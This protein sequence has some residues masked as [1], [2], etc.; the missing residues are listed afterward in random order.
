MKYI[1]IKIIFFLIFSLLFVV[2]PVYAGQYLPSHREIQKGIYAVYDNIDTD[3][4][5][6]DIF[7][8]N[9][10]TIE[11]VAF[12]LELDDSSIEYIS[13][14]WNFLNKKDEYINIEKTYTDRLSFAISS[15]GNSSLEFQ[16][17]TPILS[18]KFKDQFSGGSDI[19]ISNIYILKEGR[20]KILT[21]QDIE[22]VGGKIISPNY[23]PQA[24]LSKLAR[25]SPIQVFL[26]GFL[27]ILFLTVGIIYKKRATHF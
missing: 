1:P 5:K 18:L 24:G 15:K 10:G 11:G 27:T 12:D 9:L 16:E 2:E 13:S 14:K 25:Y 20:K 6:I 23:L 21:G 19:S 17:N 8:H 22:V 4:F 3:Y 7:M 26:Y